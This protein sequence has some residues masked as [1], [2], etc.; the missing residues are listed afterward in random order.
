MLKKR[1]KLWKRILSI[2][3]VAALCIQ[4]ASYIVYA[5]ETTSGEL[6]CSAQTG[7]SGIYEYTSFDA[8]SAGVLDVNLYL[9]TLHLCRTD[10]DIGGER[11]PVSIG[12][13][14][15]PVNATSL[16]PYGAV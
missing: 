9:G 11:M 13:Y 4:N 1:K 5:D 6:S 15:E 14:F 3:L 16:N 10:L 7:K 12:F 8:G 2:I